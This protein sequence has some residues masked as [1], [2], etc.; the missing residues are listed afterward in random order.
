MNITIASIT[1]ERITDSRG[2]PTL[3]VTVRGSDGSSGTFSVPSGAS[4]GAHEAY[5]LRDDGTSHGEVTQALHLLETE[6]QSALCG[7]NLFAQKEIDDLL[8]ELDG[9]PNKKRLG[10]NTLIGVS[11][12]LA[13]AAAH[14]QGQEF[15][16]YLHESYFKDRQ[17]QTPRLYA[18]LVNGG[19]HASTRLA[20][21]EYHIVPKSTTAS[22]A[23]A[24]ITMVQEAL[25]VTIVNRYGVVSIGDEGGYA[26]SCD[27]VAEPLTLLDDVTRTLGVRDKLD[28]ALDVA[29]SS[30]FDA[31]SRMYTIA[32]KAY[33][34]EEM[35]K[36]YKNLV[37]THD[38]LS[39]ED[40]F[41][42][43]DFASFTNLKQYIGRTMRVGDDLTT[44]NKERLM[45]AVKEGSVDAL[46][47]KPNQIGTL[48]ETIETMLYAYA[49]G[50]ACIISHRSGETLDDAIV[51]LAYGS[52]AF[53]IKIGARGPKER[54]AK[55]SR[56]LALSGKYE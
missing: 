16:Q 21:Q 42:E 48:S 44:T 33:S 43:E 26:L 41:D 45:Q 2:V 50:I 53:G 14:A 6:I 37:D 15:W 31:G 18:N 28:F 19:K 5:E 39:I 10:G 51:D 36:L 1:G 17:A 8:L 3:Q 35:T 24:L 55:Y 52:G 9:T 46:I 54:E 20:F 40:P 27:D 4:T 30:F 49:N 23:A 7:K 38:L 32:E 13:K 56:L 22:E 12:A 47:I 25:H 34:V 29:S 11:I